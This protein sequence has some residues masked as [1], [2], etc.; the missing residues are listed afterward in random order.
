MKLLFE[1][2]RQ[3][4]LTEAIA[5]S[6]VVLDEASRNA[7]LELGIPEG[8]EPVAHHMTIAPFASLVHPKGKHDFSQDYPIGSEVML[9]VVAVGRDERVMAAKVEAPGPISKKVKFP[10]ITV[11]V[12]REGGGKPKHS[13]QLPEESFEPVSGV[14]LSGIVEEV[15]M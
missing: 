5:Y 11:A 10:H 4:M 14:T 7:L 15:S 3:Y 1:N 6:G 9:P 8:W 2:W 12:N 13:N